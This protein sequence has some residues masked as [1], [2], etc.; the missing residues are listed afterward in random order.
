M[1]RAILIALLAS[2]GAPVTSIHRVLQGTPTILELLEN[3]TSVSVLYGAV[4]NNS[5]V[6]AL[7]GE[8]PLTVF[9]PIDAAFTALNA[10][11]LMKLLQPN[12][13]KHLENLFL[14]HAF[15]GEINSSY[16][17]P[18]AEAMIAMANG[19]NLTFAK[20]DAGAVTLVY[21]GENDTAVSVSVN[22]SDAVASNGIV[23]TINGLLL[24]KFIF[25]PMRLLAGQLEGFSILGELLTIA[26]PDGLPAGGEFTVF[27]PTDEAFMA[28]G[29]ESLAALKEN[30]T[31]VFTVLTHHVIQEIVPST[32]LTE[33]SNYTTLAG[34]KISVSMDGDKVMVGDATVLMPDILAIDGIIHSI[35]KV[36]STGGMGVDPPASGP[37]PTAASTPASGPVSMPAASP[38][39]KPVAAPT[40]AASF[41]TASLLVL[42]AGFLVATSQLV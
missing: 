7:E 15:S 10:T 20:D 14:Y 18:G 39:S 37:S 36:L 38:V 26:F 29:N 30:K 8:G 35:D 22:T 25:R 16:V 33:D 3:D 6:D 31:A 42:S 23:H 1:V 32:F 9:A 13:E 12:Y 41:A 2:Y 34:S 27:A 24:P 40:S 5:A 21:M 4:A 11:V 17:A 28:L 19:D